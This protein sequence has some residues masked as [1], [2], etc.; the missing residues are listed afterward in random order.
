MVGV[1]DSACDLLMRLLAADPAA[2]PSAR[3]VRCAVLPARCSHA[4]QQQLC[5]LP[6]LLASFLAAMPTSVPAPTAVQSVQATQP[7]TIAFLH[8]ICRC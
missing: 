3:Q 4:R 1:D 2:R 7:L 5:T 8:I 6:G